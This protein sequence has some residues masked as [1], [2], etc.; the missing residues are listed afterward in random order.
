MDS[1]EIRRF[2]LACGPVAGRRRVT[3]Q[4]PRPGVGARGGAAYSKPY[5]FRDPGDEKL[6]FAR[7]RT[8]PIDHLMGENVAD[9]ASTTRN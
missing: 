1:S 4:P 8:G 7:R 5:A 2:A 3:W 6:L 9:L